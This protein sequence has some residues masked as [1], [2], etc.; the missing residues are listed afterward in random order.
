MSEKHVYKVTE[1]SSDRNLGYFL[2]KDAQQAKRAALVAVTAK[3]LTGGEIVAI[4]GHGYA[5]SDAEQTL[6]RASP[7]CRSSS[8]TR[9]LP[10]RRPKTPP[11][12]HPGAA[13]MGRLP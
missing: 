8:T 11:S 7:T 9:P 12:N 3:R 1:G 10:S 2:A 5:I 13:S 6:A 4:H